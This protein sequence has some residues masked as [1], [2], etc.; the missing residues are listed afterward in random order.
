MYVNTGEFIHVFLKIYFKIKIES[1]QKIQEST[2]S[3]FY[4]LKLS[5]LKNCEASKWNKTCIV[6]RSIGSIAFF[7]DV[8]VTRVFSCYKV[9]SFGGGGGGKLLWKQSTPISRHYELDV[10]DRLS[11]DCSTT[12]KSRTFLKLLHILHSRRSVIWL[13]SK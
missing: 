8:I 5:I 2:F 6:D 9:M 3:L 10:Q 13:W 1:Y 12:E 4:A 7:V 11:I